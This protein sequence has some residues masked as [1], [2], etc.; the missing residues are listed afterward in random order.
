MH[1]ETR[2]LPVYTLTLARR[3]GKTG[4]DLRPSGEKCA[5]IRIPSSANIPNAPPPPPPPSG[6]PAPADPNVGSDPNRV[7]G[8]CGGILSPG[9]ISGRKKEFH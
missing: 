3:D 2:D 8:S 6:A 1:T 9:M 7:G 5:P 4:A